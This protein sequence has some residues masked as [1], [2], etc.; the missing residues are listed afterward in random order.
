LPATEVKASWL[1]RT[2]AAQVLRKVA[3]QLEL[4]VADIPLLPPS[5]SSAQFAA[6]IDPL[7]Y[8]RRL[9]VRQPEQ[10]RRSRGLPPRVVDD[11]GS[12]IPVSSAELDCVEVHFARFLD[13]VLGSVG[14]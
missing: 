1:G 7:G 6:S 13:D 12:A 14:P 4:N 2:G 8:R 10:R 3:P 9:R 11:W 5:S